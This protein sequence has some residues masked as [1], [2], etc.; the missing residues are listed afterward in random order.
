[1]DNE[2]NA[3]AEAI[4]LEDAVQLASD[5]LVLARDQKNTGITVL[6]TPA[7]EVTAI[8]SFVKRGQTQI[9]AGKRISALALEQAKKRNEGRKL[10]PSKQRKTQAGAATAAPVSK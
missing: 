5:I 6:N 7:E 3:N 9:D 1:M 8:R 10:P 4:S 2:S